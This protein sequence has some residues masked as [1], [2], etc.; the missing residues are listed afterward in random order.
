FDSVHSSATAS[1]GT[2][3]FSILGGAAFKYSKPYKSADD[4]RFTEVYSSTAINRYRD[5]RIDGTAIN[6]K[7]GWTKATYS[8][9]DN[10]ALELSYTRQE[11]DNVY[12][13]Y[14]SMDAVSD[15]TDRLNAT[16]KVEDITEQ[17]KELSTQ[18]YYNDVQHDMD[19]SN[20][21][22]S[23]SN[24]TECTKSMFRA[25]SMKTYAETETS[26]GRIEGK[27]SLFGTT[28][29]GVDYYVRKWG[30]TTTMYGSTHADGGGQDLRHYAYMDQNSIPN[31][32]SVNVGIY[33]QQSNDIT[34]ALK[35]VSGLRYDHAYSDATIDRSS[36]YKLYFKDYSLTNRDDDISA[37]V[38]FNYDVNKELTLFTGY[39]RSVR[40]PDATERYFALKRGGTKE[41]PDR[42]GNPYLASVKNDE[43][44]IGLKY[45]LGRALLKG[46]L[47]YSFLND[48][49]VVR[50][51]W[52]G[53]R[54]AYTYK[55]VNAAMYGGETSLNVALP[56]DLYAYAGLAYTV[57]KNETDSTYLAEIPPLNS[58][59]SL[60]YDK[61]KYFGEVE[62]VVA[63]DQDDVDGKLAEEGTSGWGILNLKAG[64]KYKD[65]TLYA[66]IANVLDN[67]YY[68]HLSYYK[69]PFSS[70]VKVPEPGRNYYFTLQYS[71]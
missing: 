49:I 47:F 68:E 24:P 41:K 39:G 8:P 66:G 1:Y 12:Y 61:T 9:I 20:R 29:F 54:Y 45:K 19:D 4:K 22:S 36:F 50:D 60:R 25:Y 62:G 58:R 55:N 16:Y 53:E 2:K 65:Y 34:D 59:V 71:L 10:H 6:M 18:F 38:Q 46:Q 64:Y 52:S 21:C 30:A 32:E 51:A 23:T 67:Q 17:F 37:N 3:R 40:V 28:A 27:F 63:S 35:V 5:D 15:D 13:P 33:A 57:G 48:F 44:D 42:V 31:V 43:M 7:S 70:G 56:Y 14:L 11:V 69:D 26:G